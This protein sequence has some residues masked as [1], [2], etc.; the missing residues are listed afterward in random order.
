LL[1]VGDYPW[2]AQFL[3]RGQNPARRHVARRVLSSSSK[4]GQQPNLAVLTDHRNAISSIV[5]LK[6]ESSPATTRKQS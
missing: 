2:I 5:P 3:V 6:A 1:V 4:N